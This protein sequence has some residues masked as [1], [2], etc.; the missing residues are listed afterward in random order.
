MNK[1]VIFALLG[2]MPLACALS[3]TLNIELGL[4]HFHMLLPA[5]RLRIQPIKSI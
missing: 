1:P 2:N 3:N 4:A 5:T